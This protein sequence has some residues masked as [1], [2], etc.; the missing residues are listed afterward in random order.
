M[1][2]STSDIPEDLIR[3]EA[4]ALGFDVCGFASVAQAWPASARL[5]QFVA[6]GHHGTMEW[7]ETSAERRAHPQ[8][9]WG[10][11]RSAVV[12]GV[13]YGPD[14]NPLDALKDK[15]RAAISVYAQGDDY[16]ELIKKRLKRLAGW[17]QQRFAGEVKVFVDTAPLMEK[18]LAE[19][20]GLGWQGKHTNLVSRELGSWFFLGSVLT[21][22]ELTPD[23]PIGEH[24]GSCQACLDIC[25]TKAFP[26]PFRLDARRCISYLTI[27]HKGPIPEEFRAALGNRIYGCDDCLAVCPWNKFAQVARESAF[28]AREHLRG[29]RLADLAALDDAGFRALFCKSPVKRIGRDRFVRNVLYAIGNSGDAALARS[30]EALLDDPSDVVR[31]AAKWAVAQL[32]P[33][34]LDGGRVGT[35]VAPSQQPLP[36][37]AHPERLPPPSPALPPSRGKGGR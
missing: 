36:L 28:H 24:C 11:A 6:D 15:S 13:G 29:P 30:A 35:G 3:V 12:L 10:D 16:H 14:S 19:L 17:M 33:F 26:T 25:P 27:E 22:L 1:T 8:V 32:K 37:A 20:A 5:A 2:I 31:D 4:L 34:P 7:I 9:M 23:A 21:T 18:P